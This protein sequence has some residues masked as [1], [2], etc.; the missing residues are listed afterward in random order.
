MLSLARRPAAETRRVPP[1][2]A[3]DDAG[4]DVIPA[5]AQHA[6]S[7]GREAAELAGVLDDLAAVGQRQRQAFN[8]VTAD[9]ERIV[10]AHKSIGTAMAASESSA[11]QARAA[12]ERVAAD[13]TG[14]LESLREV[15]GAAAEITRIAVQTRLVAFN[16]SVEAKR[17]GEAGRGFSVVADAV[18]ALAQ[19]VETSSK[20]IAGTIGQLDRRVSDLAHSIRASEPKNGVETFSGAFARVERAGGQIATAVGHASEA[21]EA[22]RARVAS[23]STEVASTG[24]AI[25]GAKQRAGKFLTTSET[26][27]ELSADSGAVTEDSPHIARVIDAAGRIGSLFEQALAA[28]EISAADLFD[29]TYQPVAGSDPKQV[30]TR[31]TA[32]TDRHLPA[33]QEAMAQVSSKVVFCAAVD[34]NGYLPTHN[35]KFSQPQGADPVWNAA[36]CRNR[37]IFADRTGLAAARNQRRFLLQTYRRD[38]G[39]GRFVLMKDLSAP[40]VVNGRHWGGLRFAYQF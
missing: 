15:A 4:R 11:Q 34:R 29:E 24:R 38:M 19:Q 9:V 39:G 31:F 23:L 16:A 6:G 14:A 33:I 37:R 32:F 3:A 40:I 8:A 26:L 5:L 27:I 36:H 17:A 20:Q 13:V 22:T 2:A 30:L 21:A 25:D 12:V 28:G 1:T 10:A 7:I 35:R 18:K